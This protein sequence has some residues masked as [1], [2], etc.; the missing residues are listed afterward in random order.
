MKSR[1]Y[2]FPVFFVLSFIALALKKFMIPFHGAFLV[3]VFDGLAIL[4]FMRAF[5]SERSGENMQARSL[6]FDLSSIIYA[7]CSIAMLYRLQYWNGW[8]RWITATG[9]LFSIVSLLNIFSIYFFFRIPERKMSVR[10]LFHAHL[11]W[12]YFVLLFPVVA[13]T[14]PRT[15]HNLFNGTTYEEYVRSRYSLDEG[16]EMIE[17]YKPESEASKKCADKLFQSALQSEKDEAYTIALRQYNESIDL[18]PDNAKA[19]YNR[20]LMKLTKLE[21]ERETAQSAYN[22]FTRALQLDS[23]MA[24]AYYHRAVAHTYLYGKNRLP[25]QIDY[26]KARTLDTSLYHDKMINAFLALPPVDSS[27]DTTNY[28]KLD[29]DE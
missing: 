12:I 5:T 29:D 20:G 17:L 10:K 28:V 9:I 14:N 27:T 22:D 15:F 8:E 16:T 21:I 3:V 18:N 23:T 4:Y 11:S 19:I 25:A 24:A 13:L 2:I 1:R 26:R 7:V 6:N